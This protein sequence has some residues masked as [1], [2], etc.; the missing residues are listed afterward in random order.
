MGRKRAEPAK[1]KA[2]A[3]TAPELKYEEGY[4]YIIDGTKRVNVGRNER[5]ATRMLEEL[6]K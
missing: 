4:W 3:K 5:Y 2:A 6:T 1:A